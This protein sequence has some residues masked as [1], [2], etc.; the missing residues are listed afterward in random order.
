MKKCIIYSIT[1][2]TLFVMF[3]SLQKPNILYDTNN[4]LKSFEYLKFKINYGFDE[5]EELICY[6]TIIFVVSLFSFIITYYI[7]NK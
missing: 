3:I 7:I 1:I 6:P 5:Y 2:Y 4:K